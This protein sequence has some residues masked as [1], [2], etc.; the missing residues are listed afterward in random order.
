MANATIS[1]LGSGLDT[2]AIVSQLMQLEAVPQSKLKSRVTSE[3]STVK[4]LQNLNTKVAALATKAGELGG[5]DSWSSLTSTSSLEGVT[6]TVKTGASASSFAVKVGALATS[7]GETYLQTAALSDVLVPADAEGRRLLTVTHQDGTTA[8][9]DTGDGT[10]RGIVDGLNATTSGS[11][12]R[13]SML[14]VSPGAYRLV[15][16]ATATGAASSFSLTSAADGSAVLGGPEATRTRT[17]ADAQIE[18]SGFT[19]TS[20]T[21]TFSE[22]MP[23][24]SLTLDAKA[25]VGE[26]AQIQITRDA[27]DHVAQVKSFVESINA[28]LTEIDAQ[29]SFNATTK[30][31]GKLAGES[32]VRDLRS[33]LAQSLYPSDGSSMASMGLEVDR[34]G[35]LVLDEERFTAAY[36]ADPTAVAQAFG[37]ADGFAAR[38]EKVA[39][40]A[41][42]KYDGTLTSA[43]KGRTDGIS[44]L[45]ESIAA[46]DLR[47]G[48]RQTAL[49]RQFTALDVALSK[50]NSQSTWLA[51]QI[52]SLSRSEG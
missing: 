50:M 36:A 28:L 27:S 45:N 8:T 2:A 15:V 11:G 37:N 40:A 10:V 48:L 38:V 47:L 39:E 23:G 4:L 18:V 52:N 44:R 20:S 30:T 35:K 1:G 14:Q 7:H 33:A 13:A 46:W 25:K 12:V 42:D 51:G 49:T 31:S 34:Y 22:I 16:D 21:N 6:T 19:L 26:S 41:S 32:G 29:S 5:A 43:V 17:G 3:E 24:V 9:V